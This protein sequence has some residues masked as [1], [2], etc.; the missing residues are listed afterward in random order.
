MERVEHKVCMV[1]FLYHRVQWLLQRLPPRLN[2]GIQ[3]EFERGKREIKGR[4]VG[5]SEPKARVFGSKNLGQ[6]SS[7]A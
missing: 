3:R 4:A 7:R 2:A 6:A 1:D 5:L